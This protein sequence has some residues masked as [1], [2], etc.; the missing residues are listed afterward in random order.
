M[1]VLMCERRLRCCWVRSGH[2]TN[3]VKASFP[4]PISDIGLGEVSDDGPVKV[5]F[6]ICL[7][8]AFGAPDCADHRRKYPRAEERSSAS[9]AWSCV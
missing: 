9:P 6:L 3:T 2:G 7:R 4:K 8:S 1:G 5:I